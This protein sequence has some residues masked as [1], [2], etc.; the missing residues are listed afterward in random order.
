MR[1]WRERAF[2]ARASAAALIRDR[3]ELERSR[4]GSAPRAP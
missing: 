4:V 3:H 1:R 2:F